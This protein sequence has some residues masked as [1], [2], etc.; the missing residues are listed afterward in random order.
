VDAI[1]REEGLVRMQSTE[2]ERAMWRDVWWT[3]FVLDSPVYLKRTRGVRKKGLVS[4][5]SCF[6]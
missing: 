1:T 6:R 2:T 5:S 3:G 4:F